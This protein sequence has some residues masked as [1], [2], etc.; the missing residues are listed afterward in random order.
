MTLLGDRYPLLLA[1]VL[2][3]APLACSDDSI[4]VAGGGAAGAGNAGGAGSGA[5]NAGGAG[6]GAAGGPVTGGGVVGGEGGVQPPTEIAPCQGMVYQCG[7][8]VD[9]DKDGL[10]DSLDP[11]C[12]GP[13]DNTEDSYF[14]DLPSNT[15]N[16]CKLDCYWDAG[17]GSGDDTCYWTHECDP[18]NVAP[19][20]YPS[21]W[22]NCEYIGE[23]GT[24]NPPGATC[25]ELYAEQS[26]LC[27]TFCGPLT[28]NGC[29]CFGCCE[30]PALSGSYVFVGSVGANED[31][32]CTLADV[33]NPDLCHPCLPVAA[34]LNDCDPCEICIGHPKPEPG[35][36]GEGGGGVG[37]GG[38]GQQCPDGV[39]E[40]G[41]SG[42]DPCPAGNSCITGCCYPV[43]E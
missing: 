41:L 30:L 26:D 42:Q 8:L 21:P 12:L 19:D 6:A 32:Q 27:G 22:I 24:T 31:T 40:C 38:G 1:A 28:P 2:V 5:G 3:A 10:L 23:D 34:C 11:D 13:C 37:G 33:G 16:S 36:E 9:N 35:C 20:F 14:P 18:N 17:D 15:N 4:N 25:A 7:D 39:Q 29:D 43:P